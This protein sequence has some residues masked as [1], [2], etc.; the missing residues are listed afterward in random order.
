MAL[1]GPASNSTCQLIIIYSCHLHI[2]NSALADLASSCPSHDK[3]HLAL[4]SSP[5]ATAPSPSP[6]ACRI[7]DSGLLC[8]VHVRVLGGGEAEAAPELR[9][10]GPCRLHRQVAPLQH[11]LPT[12]PVGGFHRNSELFRLGPRSSLGS[13]RGNTEIGGGAERR[14][15]RRYLFHDDTASSS[16]L[17]RGESLSNNGST[18]NLETDCNLILR[19]ANKMILWNSDSVEMGVECIFW[20]GKYSIAL[21]SDVD[22]SS[23]WITDS[24][25]PGQ[26]CHPPPP[27]LQ[28]LPVQPLDM[29]LRA[30]EWGR[31]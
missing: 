21:V 2:F 16:I 27:R 12:V 25:T 8:N 4:S 22:G 13:K 24:P 1:V 10:R 26:L 17:K 31:R 14:R 19:D 6:P 18:L 7:Q 9:S 15:G 3:V 28:A 23:L 29:D 20:V 11:Q 30:P 5:T